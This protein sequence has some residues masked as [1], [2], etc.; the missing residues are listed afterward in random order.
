MNILADK[1]SVILEERIKNY[2]KESSVFADEAGKMLF[3]SGGIV[4]I[5]GLNKGDTLRKKSSA[6]L[7]L[8]FSDWPCTDLT[9]MLN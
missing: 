2:Y 3:V 4:R 5:Y 9:R 1:L 8:S 6:F 7:E